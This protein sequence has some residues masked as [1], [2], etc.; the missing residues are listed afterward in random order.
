MYVLWLKFNFSYEVFGFQ[1]FHS[2][3]KCVAELT[4]VCQEES[5]SVVQKFVADIKVTINFLGMYRN[6][7]YD[8]RYFR[9]GPSS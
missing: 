1:A 5:Q 3:A 7:S 2:I 4:L 6:F 8:I 9:K